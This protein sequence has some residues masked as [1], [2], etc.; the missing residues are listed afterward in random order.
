MKINNSKELIIKAA[1]ELYFVKGKF[2]I[3][4]KDIADFAGIKRPLIYYYFNSI[5]ELM[6]KVVTET[7]SERDLLIHNVLNEDSKLDEKLEKIFDLH[8]THTIKYPFRQ[9]YLATHSNLFQSTEIKQ[10]L[11]YKNFMKILE[12]FQ[13]SIDRNQTKIK[14]AKQAMVLFLSYLNY[15]LLMMSWGA[16]VLATSKEEYVTLLNERKKTFINLLFNL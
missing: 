2:D 13:N 7:N 3:T 14:D 15:P 1:I 4:S 8:L 6:L 11:D 16:E 12:L 10:S 5:E 9:M